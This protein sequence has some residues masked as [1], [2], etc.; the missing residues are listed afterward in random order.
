MAEFLGQ[1]PTMSDGFPNNLGIADVVEGDPAEA[2]E[3]GEEF[4]ASQ[5]GD[6]GT[7]SVNNSG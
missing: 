5:G 3:P 7:L 2:G 6:R 4:T 1:L